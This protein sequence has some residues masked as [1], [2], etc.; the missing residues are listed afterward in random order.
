MSLV[1][2]IRDSSMQHCSSNP[3]CIYFPMVQMTLLGRT[4][5]KVCSR[6]KEVAPLGFDTLWSCHRRAILSSSLHLP[7]TISD[8]ILSI[9]VFSANS[10]TQC[11]PKALW[12]GV[13][14]SRHVQQPPGSQPPH[15]LKALWLL[16]ENGLFSGPTSWI[17]NSY[18]LF[19]SPLKAIW[20]W[21]SDQGWARSGGKTGLRKPRYNSYG[22]CISPENP[23]KKQAFPVWLFL[24]Q[25]ALPKLP[26]ALKTY[27]YWL[28]VFLLG[29]AELRPMI[30]PNEPP[31]HYNKYNCTFSAVYK[32]TL[33]FT[34]PSTG[35]D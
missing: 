2:E 25:N 23:A 6:Q 27:P 20:E 28:E 24:T 3:C 14:Y 4:F 16:S 9:H 21:F 10:W 13:P 17:S 8:S 32:Y 5:Q 34:L 31:F 1:G 30:L 22:P 15:Y 29:Y 11:A 18:Y 35:D 12:R 19:P 7:F 33:S 26:Q